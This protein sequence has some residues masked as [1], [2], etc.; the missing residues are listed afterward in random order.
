MDENPSDFS[1]RADQRIARDPA[2]SPAQLAAIVQYRPDLWADVALNPS[3]YPELLQW[4]SMTGDPAVAPALAQRTTTSTPPVGA[5]PVVTPPMPVSPTFP[6]PGFPPGSGTSTPASGSAPASAAPAPGVA[7]ASRRRL[8]TPVVVLG[9]A[10]ALVVG[11]GVGWGVMAWR[12]GEFSSAEEASASGDTSDLAGSAASTPDTSSAP[13][14]SATA[15]V[16]KCGTPPTFTPTQV[17]DDNG[18]LKVSVRITATCPQGDVLSGPDNQVFVTAP[19][20]SDG[21]GSADAVVA[22]GS[23]DFSANPVVIPDAGREL[24]FTFPQGRFFRTA[25]DL[26]VTRIL[27]ACTPDTSSDVS[28]STAPGQAGSGGEQDITASSDAASTDSEDD[29]ASALRWQADHDKPLVMSSL[30]GRWTPQLS[31]KKPGLVADGRTWDNRATLGEFLELRQRF[32]TVRLL[33]SDEWSVFNP[34]GHWWVTVAGVAFGTPE[35]ANAWCD[36]QGF[37]AE[38]CYAKYIDPN[39]SPAGSTRQ[40]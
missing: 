18:V 16:T 7:E 40:R 14:G 38:H 25:R 10:L 26:D 22:T 32:S 6:A 35:E 29:A 4:L 33:Y 9:A 1:R 2:T 19:S 30:V 8:L 23:F 20:A 15:Y 21:S 27:V 5:P 3:T 13:Q 12:G 34:G 36:Q 11:A 24:T 37:D 28:A 17:I 39:G 31:S